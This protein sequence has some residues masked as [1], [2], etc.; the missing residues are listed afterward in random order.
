[1]K[2]TVTTTY[3]NL[4]KESVEEAIVKLETEGWPKSQTERIREHGIG[5]IKSKDPNSE[6]CAET[7]FLIDKF[8]K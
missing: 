8:A 4:S 6:Q 1:M 2:I 3:E 7:I 5:I